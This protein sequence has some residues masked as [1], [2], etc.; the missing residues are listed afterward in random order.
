MFKTLFENISPQ[1]FYYFSSKI[2]P[3]AFLISLLF[4]GYGLYLGLFVAPLDYQQGDAFRIIYVHVPSA[5][6]SLFAYSAVFVCSIIALIWKIKV[7]EILTIA[8]AKNGAL[9][10]FLALITG[11]IWGK[12]MWG[13]WWVWDARLTSELIL[14]FIYLSIIFL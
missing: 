11:S 6:L 4:I 8:S 7:F 2:I 14:F 5:W 1:K 12:P 10:T 9:F 3:W 13:T